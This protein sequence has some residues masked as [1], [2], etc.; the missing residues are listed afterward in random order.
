MFTRPTLLLRIEETAVLVAAVLAYAHL[1]F[2]WMLFAVLFFAPDLFMVGYLANPRV[3]RRSTISRT[4]FLCRSRS[5]RSGMGGL[6]ARGG[7]RYHLD[8][9]YRVRPAAGVW[10]EISDTL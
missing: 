3:G 7:G 2:S 10:V 8:Q 5:S 6:T 1:H 4:A 9:P